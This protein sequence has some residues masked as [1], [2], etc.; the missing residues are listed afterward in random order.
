MTGGTVAD[1]MKAAAKTEV[2][3]VRA[4][5]GLNPP[6]LRS[7]S[8]EHQA[9]ITL[10]GLN[11]GNCIDLFDQIL[12]Q[13]VNHRA[14]DIHVECRDKDVRLRFRIDGLMYQVSELPRSIHPQLISR[15]KIVAG[16]D[17]AEKRLPQDG[18]FTFRGLPG[19][20]D[21][22][23]STIPAILGE[24]A[25]IRIL[26]R[27]QAIT[28]MGEL[29]LSQNNLRLLSGLSKRSHGLLLVTGP[30]GSG[31]T[32]TLYALLHSINTA[33]KNIVTLEDPVEYSLE[34]IN[35][36][37][38]NSKAGLRFANGLRSALRQDPDVIMVGEVRDEETAQLAVHA[39][40]TGHLVLSTLHTNSAAAAVTRLLDMGCASYLLASALSGI[41]SQRLVRLLC[42]LCQ[43]SYRISAPQAAWLKRPE[44][45]GTVMYRSA[46][47][48]QCYGLGYMGRTAIQEIMVINAAL[49]KAVYKGG[50]SEDELQ[51]LAIG[52]HMVPLK[53]DGI[54]KASQG[55]TSLEEILRVITE[56]Q[57]R[58]LP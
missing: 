37:Q 31:K 26:D 56:D 13:A 20:V 10:A 18:R 44:L 27:S 21:C 28:A 6:L 15:I 42:P 58:K 35:Q 14:S 32:S 19:K 51:A 8:D 11:S 36:V 39:A 25:V 38:I 23:V 49:K 30:T 5:G 7:G 50:A 17:I 43:Q 47:C 2:G 3:T 53:W 16:M 4:P 1:Q 24:K 34:N 40:L 33:H 48:S 45:S 55:L 22:R 41:V 29:G 12:H 57:E 46:G 9:H 52:N 54:D